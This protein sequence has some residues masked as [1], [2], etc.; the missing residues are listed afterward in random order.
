[1]QKSPVSV[2]PMGIRNSM[3]VMFLGGP[4]EPQ[5]KREPLSSSPRQD[6]LLCEGDRLYRSAPK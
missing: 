2:T 4:E 3:N 6:L 1:M 5:L